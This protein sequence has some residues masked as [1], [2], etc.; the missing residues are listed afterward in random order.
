[1]FLVQK[2]DSVLAWL[3]P[4]DISTDHEDAYSLRHAKSG[5]WLLQDEKY[6]EWINGSSSS[7]L[8]CYGKRMSLPA[9]VNVKSPR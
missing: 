5:S 2:R 6:Q 8:W 9:S 3:S 1:M 7:L 4:L